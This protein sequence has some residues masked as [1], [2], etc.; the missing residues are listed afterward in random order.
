MLLPIPILLS[1]FETVDTTKAN[2]HARTM[3]LLCSF[4]NYLL[5][6]EPTLHE[7][8]KQQTQRVVAIVIEPGIQLPLPQPAWIQLPLPTL[9]AGK[10]W[11][12]LNQGYLFE[13]MVENNTDTPLKGD[14]TITIKTGIVSAP[15]D[16]RLRWIHIEGDALLAKNLF[17]LIEHLRWDITQDLANRI[18]DT[19]AYWLSAL[20]QARAANLNAVISPFLTRPPLV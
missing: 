15:A 4:I 2:I 3:A 20:V 13:P 12:R 7:T 1:L 16:E 10:H 17:Y 8:L 6:N 18:G 19:P 9:P 5:L 14:V 11:L